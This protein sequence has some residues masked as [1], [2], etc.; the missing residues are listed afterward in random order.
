MGTP[1]GEDYGLQCNNC[2]PGEFP[3]GE[4][5]RWAGV[6]FSGIVKCEGG[7]G[8]EEPPNRFFLA[9]QDIACMWVFGSALYTGY[10][11]ARGDKT[12]VFCTETGGGVTYFWS[13][14]PGP[15]D[16]FADSERSC[17]WGHDYGDGSVSIG[18]HGGPSQLFA[19]DYNFAPFPNLMYEE[20]VIDADNL[21][22][23]IA[24][25]TGQVNILFTYDKTN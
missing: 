2:T 13:H 10:W 14:T 24:D 21:M 8:V 16:M 5:P 12:I 9:E 7:A 15:C 17:D 20:W 25:G 23:R 1:V 3:A 6:A 18:G 4:T 22:Y 19:N 11:W